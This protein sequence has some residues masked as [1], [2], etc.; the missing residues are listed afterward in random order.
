MEFKVCENTNDD[1]IEDTHKL[2]LTNIADA[3]GMLITEPAYGAVNTNDKRS[4]GFYVVKFL[5]TVYMLQHGEVA[6]KEMMKAGSLVTD[7]EYMSPA[8]KDSL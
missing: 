5:S 2:I 8:M 7:I 3:T 6:D 1:E 4:D